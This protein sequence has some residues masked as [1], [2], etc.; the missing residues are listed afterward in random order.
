MGLLNKLTQGG[1]SP[2]SAANGGT[3]STNPLASANSN[4][5]N[6]YSITGNGFAA[7][8]S[9]YQQYN[10]GAANILPQPSQLDLGGTISPSSKYL[11]NLP[12]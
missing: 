7:I 1:G 9:A 10:D 11:N 6:D 8:N 2:L 12:Q 5:H 4:L 3:I